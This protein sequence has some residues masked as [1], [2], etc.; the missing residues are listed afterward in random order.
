[1]THLSERELDLPHLE[2]PKI[3]ARVV[4]D[5]SIISL[6]PGEPDFKAPKPLLDYAKKILSKSTHYSEPQGMFQ[7]REAL[8]RKLKKENKINTNPENIVLTCGSQEALFSALLTTI[9]PTEQVLIP[10]PGYLG[11]LPAIELVNGNPIYYPLEEKDKFEINPDNIKSLI[12]KKKTKAIIINSPSNPTGNVLS[13]K[14][15]E[16]LAGI[17]VENDLYIF[18]DEAYQHLIYEDKHISIASLNGMKNYVITFQT[19]SKSYAMCGFRLGYA[20]G[21]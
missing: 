5:K 11:Y 18:S 4:N 20:V 9:D 14:V 21:P 17:A 7:L 15:L 8:C 19:F 3:F 1:M 2:F 10:S 13:K 12:D 16:E 6:G